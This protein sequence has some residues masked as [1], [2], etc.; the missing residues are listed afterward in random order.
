MQWYKKQPRHMRIVDKPDKRILCVE[1]AGVLSDVSTCDECYRFCYTGYYRHIS[2]G[3]IALLLVV[4]FS[5][6]SLVAVVG[7]LGSVTAISSRTRAVTESKRTLLFA[8]GVLDDAVYRF[9]SG[10]QLQNGE[11]VVYNDIFGDLSAGINAVTNSGITTVSVFATSTGD[12]SRNMGVTIS[13]FAPPTFTDA[14]VVGVGGITMNSNSKII[15]SAHSNGSILGNSNSHITGDASAVGTISSPSPTVDGTNTSGVDPQILPTIDTEYWKEL[16][17]SNNDPVAG[18]LTLNGNQTATYGPRRFDGDVILNSNSSLTVLGTLHITGSL[19]LNSNTQ[20]IIDD[21]L[22]SDGVVIIVDGV[23]N[24]NS[25]HPP[26]VPTNAEPPGYPVIVSLTT[27]TNAITLNSNSTIKGLLY[28]PN[29]RVIV[30]S[31]SGA[32]SVVSKGLLL[33]SNAE[34]DFDSSVAQQGHGGGTGALSL[35][36]WKEIE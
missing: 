12:L 11:V 14:V 27:N 29:G 19:T 16:A 23:V 34:I 22:G 5:G 17:N 7:G 32:V 1:R 10:K 18:G 15:G 24:F 36:G 33:N 35:D 6:A 20:L 25:S 30:N 13:T 9:R 21:S 2:R 3:A 28:A 4:L 8:D 26:I 31:N